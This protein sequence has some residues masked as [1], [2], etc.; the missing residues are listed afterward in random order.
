MAAVAIEVTPEAADVLR[1]SLELAGL[2]GEDAGARLRAARGLGRGLEFQVELADGPRPGERVVEAHGV[3]LYVDPAVT[4]AIPR[5]VVTVE[6]QHS[7][8]VVRPDVGGS[9]E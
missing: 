4:R 5:A 6:P 2:S 7:T 3:K 9:L 1:R 8:V